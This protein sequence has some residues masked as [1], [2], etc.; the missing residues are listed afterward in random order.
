MKH[1][2]E[3]NGNLTFILEGEADRETVQDITQQDIHQDHGVLAELLDQFGLLGNGFDTCAVGL[4]DAPML[5]DDIEY[6]DN[7][8]TKV[9]GTV[10][11][12]PA[13][14]IKAFA[15]ELLRDGRVTFTKACDPCVSNAC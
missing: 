2:V 5:T 6:Q 13:Y 11:W 14:E 9:R 15:Q 8:E 1:L 3:P 4:T 10:W 12:Y 7:G